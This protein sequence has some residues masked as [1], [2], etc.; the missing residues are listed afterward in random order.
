VRRAL[1][2]YVARPSAFLV[3]W[4]FFVLTKPWPYKPI[5]WFEWR[6]TLGARVLGNKAT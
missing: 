6:E 4:L 5:E 1:W 2:L 3:W